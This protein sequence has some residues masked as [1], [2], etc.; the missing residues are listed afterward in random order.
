MVDDQLKL[1]GALALAIYQSHGPRALTT[2]CCVFW[3]S[4][5]ALLG[6]RPPYCTQNAMYCQL[7]RVLWVLLRAATP[8][9]WRSSV[10]RTIL[11]SRRRATDRFRLVFKHVPNFHALFC[12][13]PQSPA[14]P[15]CAQSRKVQMRVIRGADSGGTEP[16]AVTQTINYLTPCPCEANNST[17]NCQFSTGQVLCTQHTFIW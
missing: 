15:S 11:G 16:S 14:L 1:G 13:R 5:L 7:G 4:Y 6:S 10:S 12:L 17:F 9:H 3:L 8:T 2:T